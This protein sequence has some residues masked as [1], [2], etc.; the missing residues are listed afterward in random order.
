[1]PLYPTISLTLKGAISGSL[2]PFASVSTPSNLLLHWEFD[3]GSGT[4]IAATAGP[5]GYIDSDQWITGIV[6]DYA[7]DMSGANEGGSLSTIAFGSNVLSVAFWL[8]AGTV[9]AGT[10][11][12]CPSAGSPYF[13][14]EFDSSNL[15]ASIYSG[16][17][18]LAEESP[19]FTPHANRWT[20]V[21]AVLDNSTVGGEIK[22]YL[23]GVLQ[24]DNK[25]VE[26]K[27][28]T[29]NFATDSIQIGESFVP[30]FD[31]SMD[32][33]RIYSTELTQAQVHALIALAPTVE[34]YEDGTP[35]L[36]EDGTLNFYA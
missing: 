29:S 15:K 13:V 2:R 35:D 22:I 33:L 31:G 9:S 20:H 36:N 27:S 11:L 32:D 25:T 14:V 10:I 26:T 8:K 5:A 4:D 3:E 23:N 34:L 24:A 17:G 19:V 28:G 21:A 1:M 30:Q 7:V 6:G 16:A 18:Q 12:K